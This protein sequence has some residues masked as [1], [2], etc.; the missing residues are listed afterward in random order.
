[1]IF[2]HYFKDEK[3]IP[4]SGEESS[5]AGES[6]TDEASSEDEDKYRKTRSRPAEFLRHCKQK[7]NTDEQR[8]Q[9]RYQCHVCEKVLSSSTILGRHME[10]HKD[11]NHVCSTCGKSY[12]SMQLLKN[13]MRV[14]R[15]D[16]ICDFC[17]KSFNFYCD[18]RQHEGVHFKS[19]QP[20]DLSCKQCKVTFDS[21]AVFLEHRKQVHNKEGNVEQYNCHVCGKVLSCRKNL[22]NHVEL[23]NK[24]DPVRSLPLEPCEKAT[25]SSSVLLQQYTL[26]HAA[27]NS[28][29]G[30]E[31]QCQT[32]GRSSSS[33]A[34]A[35]LVKRKKIYKNEHV[36][37][38]C[39]L[40][41]GNLESLK[42][43]I[44]RSHAN[45]PEKINVICQFCGKSSYSRLQL[46]K[47]VR[48]HHQGKKCVCETCGKSFLDSTTLKRHTFTHSNDKPFT[49]E[50]CGKGV[51]DLRNHQIDCLEKLNSDE[52]NFQ[53]SHCD[54]TFHLEI[55]LKRHEKKHLNPDR[56]ECE[57]CHKKFRL[58]CFLTQHRRSH[59]PEE[60]IPCT[61]C[62]NRFRRPQDLTWHME[63]DHYGNRETCSIC[64]Y[65]A[66]SRALFKVH[67]RTHKLGRRFECDLCDKKFFKGSHMKRHRQIHEK[68]KN[69]L[70]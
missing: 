67:E 43:H 40:Q 3:P 38:G 35:S 32:N 69:L 52:R 34:V 9:E 57:V 48:C 56:F 46:L 58:Q 45:D 1:M 23:H 13:H 28:E 25:D 70:K 26:E 68:T 21:M 47:H 30:E 29:V 18:L 55:S 4:E 11:G 14:H 22:R 33:V 44:A 36:C 27:E 65:E 31:R 66:K 42:S 17:G 2:C 60:R 39:G 19:L 53:C 24:K 8:D 7:D 61:L 20:G 62:S 64:G 41:F 51:T 49:C 5:W 37:E 12:K 6:S 54:K 63:Y 10:L 50:L 15:R 16:K 59:F